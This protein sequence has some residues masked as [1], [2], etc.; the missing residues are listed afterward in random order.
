MTVMSFGELAPKIAALMSGG[1][2]YYLMDPDLC[3][4]K[5]DIT[6]ACEFDLE[7]DE[8]QLTNLCVLVKVELTTQ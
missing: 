6:A 2:K 4:D 1:A 3:R 7:L 5:V 8:T